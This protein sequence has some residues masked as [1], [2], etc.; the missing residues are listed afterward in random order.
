[1][2]PV[3]FRRT[4]PLKVQQ[5]KIG[6]GRAPRLPETPMIKLP[7]ISKANFAY[8]FIY[9]YIYTLVFIYISIEIR[10]HLLRFISIPRKN[11]YCTLISRLKLQFKNSRVLTCL[12]YFRCTFFNRPIQMITFEK[13]F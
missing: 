7:Q 6:G 13:I 1:M 10:V 11:L 4:C 5:L 3:K 9:I 12:N 2:F 8:G